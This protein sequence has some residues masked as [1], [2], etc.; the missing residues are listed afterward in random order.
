MCHRAWLSKCHDP[1]SG[2]T[3]QYNENVV[4]I[5]SLLLPKEILSLARIRKKKGNQSN[6]FDDFA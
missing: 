6:Y 5:F 3:G 2:Q 1:E 4:Y